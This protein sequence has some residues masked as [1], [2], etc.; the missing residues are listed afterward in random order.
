MPDERQVMREHTV[1]GYTILSARKDPLME[2]AAQ[3]ALHHH[4]R[5][6]G[7]GYPAG[8]KGAEIPLAA[9][10]VGMADMFDALTHTRAYKP[11]WSVEAAL[12][13]MERHSRGYSEQHFETR[14][15]DAFIA[16]VRELVVEYG[17]GGLDGYL[18]AR[19]IQNSLYNARIAASDALGTDFP[20]SIEDVTNT[21]HWERA[22]ATKGAAAPISPTIT[23]LCQ[24]IEVQLQHLAAEAAR[25]H[26]R[27]H[28]WDWVRGPLR[29]A[30]PHQYALIAFG[31]AH[32]LGIKLRDFVSVDLPEAYLASLQTGDDELASPVLERWLARREMM[33][34]TAASFVDPQHGN[35]LKNFQSNGLRDVLIDGWTDEKSQA[36]VLLKLYNCHPHAV[37][38]MAGLRD[39]VRMALEQMWARILEA[40]LQ[41]RTAQLPA[42]HMLT[43]AEKEVLKWVKLGKT[44]IEIAQILNKSE[45][46][47]KTQVQKILDKTGAVNRTAL[48]AIEL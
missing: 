25:V 38:A 39:H 43:P 26:T 1:Q 41:M 31:H 15:A 36:V 29:E 22:V 46:T 3:I 21:S 16:M 23:S 10:I 45:Y 5:W 6:D 47:V 42:M 20:E 37:A 2:L 9:Q 17:E 34:V 19:A 30:V 24:L 18:S 28:L 44:N 33:H 12:A 11:A 8:L 4:E 13:E 48:A 14:L 35:W 32:A 40:E 27:V 7:K